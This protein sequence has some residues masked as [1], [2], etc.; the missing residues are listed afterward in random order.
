MSYREKLKVYR[1]KTFRSNNTYNGYKFELEMKKTEGTIKL[2]P[3]EQYKYSEVAYE[4]IY[5]S[6]STNNCQIVVASNIEKLM[7][8]FESKFFEKENIFEIKVKT[9]LEETLL[10]PILL[11]DIS[12]KAR[13]NLFKVFPNS[14]IYS[15]MPY[16]STFNGGKRNIVLLKMF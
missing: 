14:K 6:Q 2:T 4:K 5:L 10:S 8:N 9:L 7:E 15:E 11:L 16:R 1:G 3:L 13:N 12:E